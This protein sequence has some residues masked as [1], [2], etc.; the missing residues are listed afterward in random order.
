MEIMGI[1][2]SLMSYLVRNYTERRDETHHTEKRAHKISEII[3]YVSAHY[4][5][6][7]TTARLAEHF[8]LSE[9]YF[10]RFFK[11][12]TGLTPTDYI[13]KYRVACAASLIK[14]TDLPITEIAL[15]VGFVDSNYFT[16][17]FKKYKGKTPRE[18]KKI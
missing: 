15:R 6:H 4:A 5:E 7:L 16:K 8:F 17:I 2:Y 10:C 12:S 9:Y 11:E 1:C 14:S 13:N 3:G 18:F